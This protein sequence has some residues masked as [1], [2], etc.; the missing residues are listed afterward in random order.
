MLAYFKKLPLTKAVFCVE[1]Q[2]VNILCHLVGGLLAYE[3]NIS[4]TLLLALHSN[5]KPTEPE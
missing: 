2:C 1:Y 3:F 5:S 4:E